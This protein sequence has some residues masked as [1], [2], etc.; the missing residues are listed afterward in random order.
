MEMMMY[1]DI[2]TQQEAI[3]LLS[4]LKTVTCASFDRYTGIYST[5]L[6]R[7]VQMRPMN[8]G[9]SLMEVAHSSNTFYV[10]GKWTQGNGTLRVLRA[11]LRKLAGSDE[12]DKLSALRKSRQIQCAQCG[13]DFM[14][15]SPI[16]KFCSGSCRNMF[17]RQ[18]AAKTA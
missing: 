2:P 1:G 13:V 8:C 10:S 7:I 4:V 17:Y 12:G 11:E 3:D 18:A 6:L 14:A 16:A 9:T 15:K 5:D